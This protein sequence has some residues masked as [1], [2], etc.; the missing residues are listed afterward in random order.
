MRWV[1][2]FLAALAIL[3][4]VLLLVLRYAPIDTL[5]PE[6]LREGPTTVADIVVQRKGAGKTSGALFLCAESSFFYEGALLMGAI[7][8]AWARD[9]D[10]KFALLTGEMREP[11]L[12]AVQHIGISGIFRG[13]RNLGTRNFRHIKVVRRKQSADPGSRSREEG[14]GTVQKILQAIREGF[15]VFVFRSFG[16]ERKACGMYHVLDGLRDTDA[17]FFVVNFVRN[18]RG[19]VSHISPFPTDVSCCP[20]FIERLDALQ[21]AEVET[22]AS[23]D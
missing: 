7:E 22:P 12:A 10:T 14:S 23:N 3:L 18:P 8:A 1:H 21:S 2:L 5:L 6:E 17:D 13:L 20:E 11:H 16:K 19:R 9:A 4:V 15:Y